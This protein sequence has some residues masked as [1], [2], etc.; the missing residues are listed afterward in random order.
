MHN[1][2]EAERLGMCKAVDH[3]YRWGNT[4]FPSIPQ[5]L[6]SR[7]VQSVSLSESCKEIHPQK[8]VS[9]QEKQKVEKTL[10]FTEDF[11]TVKEAS[12]KTI[13]EFVLLVRRGIRTKCILLLS[14]VAYSAHQKSDLLGVQ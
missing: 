13:T 4:T 1:R 11:H 9:R 5:L 8:H 14:S 3:K 7:D 12:E 6:F 2:L 10:T